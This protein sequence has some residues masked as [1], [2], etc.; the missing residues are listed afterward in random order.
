MCDV[1]GFRFP[2]FSHASFGIILPVVEKDSKGECMV[3]GKPIIVTYE[4]GREEEFPSAQNCAMV[5]NVASSTVR[6]K[7]K[8]G[9]KLSWNGQKIGFRFK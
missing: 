9:E 4:N 2:Y 7:N 3:Q 6:K 5:L 8:S 1:S